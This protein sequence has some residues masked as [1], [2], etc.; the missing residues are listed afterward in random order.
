M[1]CTYQIAL[2]IALACPPAFGADAISGRN[3]AYVDWAVKYCG[4]ESTDKEHALVDQAY[5]KGRDEFI[6]QYTEQSNKLG[7]APDAQEKMCADIKAWYGPLGSR[8]A[9]LLR[10]KQEARAEGSASAPGTSAKR[11]GKRP[12]VSW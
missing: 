7:P 12:S 1:R 6:A 4:A 8:I 10:W 2:G 5:T 9:D 3:A 11:K